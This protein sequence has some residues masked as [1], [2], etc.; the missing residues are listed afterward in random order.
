MSNKKTEQVETQRTLEKT[1]MVYHDLFVLELT[2]TRKNTSWTD[3][4][5]WEPLEH[6]HYFHS[7]D[8]DGK[9][10]KYCV[11][12]AG[13]YHEVKYWTNPE[14]GKLEAECGPPLVHH[15]GKSYPYKNDKHTHA[16]TY[17]Y[18]EEIEKRKKNSDAAN[19]MAQLAKPEGD[20]MRG[21]AG[22]VR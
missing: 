6:K 4:P 3:Q 8:S 11:A 17:R 14:T 10:H 16:V 22:I 18:S 7:C 21:A 9:N 20:A 19:A 2:N 5:M 1:E 15:K 13:H 12:S